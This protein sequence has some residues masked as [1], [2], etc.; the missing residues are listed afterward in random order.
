MKYETSRRAL[1]SNTE[2]TRR[3]DVGPGDDVTL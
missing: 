1:K 3:L 2:R